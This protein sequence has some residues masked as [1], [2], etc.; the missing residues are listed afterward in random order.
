MRKIPVSLTFLTLGLTVAAVI[1]PV[2][3]SDIPF[4]PGTK[5]HF[6]SV[7]EGQKVLMTEDEFV[8]HL[9]PFD[10]AS[11]IKTDKPVS[12]DEYLAFVGKNVVE[13]TADEIRAVENAL[14]EIQS[15]L[16]EVSLAFPATIQMIKTT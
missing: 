5:V 2:R 11:R 13:W 10:R 4:G 7:S 3:G 15:R 1:S 9:S 12:E 16:G 6:A 8:R 14:K